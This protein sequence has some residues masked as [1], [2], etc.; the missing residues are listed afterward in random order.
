MPYMTKKVC[1]CCNEELPATEFRQRTYKNGN[2]YLYSQ[3]K[4][5]EKDKVYSYRE[6]N[7]EHLNAYNRERYAKSVGGLKRMSPLNNTDE[8][9]RMKACVK[10]TVRNK[11]TKTATLSSEKE[12]TDLV[13]KEMV[14]SKKDYLERYGEEYHIDHI[15]PLK[16]E[17]VCGLHVWYNLQLMPKLENLKKGNRFA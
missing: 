6:E 13:V 5:C 9:R 14:L 17:T 7:K 4:S 16:G 15:V 11:R 3:C 10:A 2:K 1:S 12:F 8:H